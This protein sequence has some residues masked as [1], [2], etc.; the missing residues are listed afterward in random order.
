MVAFCSAPLSSISKPAIEREQ[1]PQTGNAGHLLLGGCFISRVLLWV[2]RD[3][4]IF[5]SY[6]QFSSLLQGLIDM[7]R[8]QKSPRNGCLTGRK[9]GSGVSLFNVRYGQR[10]RFFDCR[11]SNIT[12]WRRDQRTS[13]RNHPQP[14]ERFSGSQRQDIGGRVRRLLRRFIFALLQSSPGE[15][16]NFPVRVL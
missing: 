7:G 8:R 14:I 12:L 10:P 5:G 4:S 11:N 3:L 16:K 2:S 9:V 1:Q 6:L 13:R 15:F